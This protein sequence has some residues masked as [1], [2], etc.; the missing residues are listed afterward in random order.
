GET[1]A[2]DHVGAGAPGHRHDLV[3]TLAEDLD[4]GRSE[5]AGGAG[6]GDLPLSC[7]GCFPFGLGRHLV[8]VSPSCGY[9][10]AEGRDVTEAGQQDL[11]RRFEQD[12]RRLWAVAFRMLGA[13]GEAD[14][15]VQEAWL[16][17]A[18][19][20]SEQIENLSSWL[21]TVVARI[22]LDML[23]ARKARQE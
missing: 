10:G 20:D 8:A 18:R 14:E 16:R 3:P 12:R 21:T 19:S 1:L 5:P 6:D 11:A 2:G 13:S 17:L 9:D 22:C 15:A 23:R 4:G 7:H